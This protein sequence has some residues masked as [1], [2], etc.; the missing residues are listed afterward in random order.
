MFASCKQLD[1]KKEIKI[2]LI[3]GTVVEER[4]KSTKKPTPKKA[5][6]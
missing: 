3:Q 2:G 6:K 1:I 4:L 5:V